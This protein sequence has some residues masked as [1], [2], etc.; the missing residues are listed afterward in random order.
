[1]PFGVSDRN[2]P[3]IVLY[4][5]PVAVLSQRKQYKSRNLRVGAFDIVLYMSVLNLVDNFE[6]VL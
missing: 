1:M 6:L 3:Q 2:N 5:K 4:T